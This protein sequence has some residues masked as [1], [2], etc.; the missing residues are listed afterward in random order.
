MKLQ[1]VA[2]VESSAIIA[3]GNKLY[4]TYTNKRKTINYA[5]IEYQA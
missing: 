4:I 5:F 1:R 2:I 3:E